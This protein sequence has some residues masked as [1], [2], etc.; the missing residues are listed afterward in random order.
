MDA[1]DAMTQ[2]NILLVGK[3]RET[4]FSAITELCDSCSVIDIG[5]LF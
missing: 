4:F 2:S 3:R 5:D 1:V